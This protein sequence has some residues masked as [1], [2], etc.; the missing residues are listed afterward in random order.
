MFVAATETAS[1]FERL[2]VP[3]VLSGGVATIVYG[4]PRSTLD[5][6]FAVHMQEGQARRL[7]QL[8]GPSF[9]VDPEAAIEAARAS[10]MF[11]MV[12]AESFMKIDVH[13]VP[14][15]GLHRLEIERG[16]RQRLGPG[17]P[18]E[19][20]IVTPEDLLLQKLRWYLDGGGVSEKQ[21]RDVLG[22]LKVRGHSLDFDYVRRWA[23]ELDTLEVLDRALTAAG[24]A[25]T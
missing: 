23:T 13:V 17:Y 19:I 9:L 1:L 24:V 16:R 11:T 18:D 4:E 20:R 21:W 10:S 25:P 3:Y 12:H 14:R 15:T 5:V 2:G 7:P 22:I 8:A 6:D